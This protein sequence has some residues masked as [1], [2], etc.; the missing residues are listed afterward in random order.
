[1]LNPRVIQS[2]TGDWHLAQAPH[3]GFLGC[4]PQD[5]FLALFGE[6]D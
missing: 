6:C 3:R 4:L 5:K 1:M 2:S